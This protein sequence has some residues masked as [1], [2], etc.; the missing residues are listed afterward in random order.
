MSDFGVEIGAKR[1]GLLHELLPRAARFGV[2]V[3][4][5]NPAFTKSFVAELQPAASAIGREIEVVTASTNS[6]IDVAF[7]ALVKRH[8]RVGAL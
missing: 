4:P 6:D 8:H 3:N 1:L 5:D 2:L 7:R